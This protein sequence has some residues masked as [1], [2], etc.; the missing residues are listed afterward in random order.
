[1]TSQPP[2]KTKSACSSFSLGSRLNTATFP[3]CFWTRYAYVDAGLTYD[4]RWPSLSTAYTRKHISEQ[5]HTVDE[6]PIT[7]HISAL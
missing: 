7:R 3:P 4:I 5:K 6:V 2:R 1:M